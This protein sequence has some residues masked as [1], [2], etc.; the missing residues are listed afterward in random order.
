[1]LGTLTETISREANLAY[2]IIYLIQNIK[3]GKVYVGQTIQSLARRKGEHI[4]RMKSGERNHKLYM[5]LRKYGTGNFAWLII[6]KC[7][8][9][10]ELNNMEMFYIK[11]FNSYN[12]GYNMNPGGYSVG[13][14]T[15]K[16]LSS[17]F[18]GRVNTWSSRSAAT[19]KINFEAGLFTMETAKG[20]LNVNSK[21]YVITDKDGI[22]HNVKGLRAWCREWDKDVL[23]HNNLVC[24]AKGLYK[25]YK[26]YK[27]RYADVEPSTTIPKGSTLKR[28][29]MGDIL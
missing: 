24:C 26:G 6:R 7:D 5:A 17:I 13:E 3:N 11:F 22:E 28:V 19:R 20:A 14:E 25:T 10:E 2:G 27:C 18:K 9:H 23:I 8:S 15:R 21:S 12:R 16:K 4:Y 29:E 1:L